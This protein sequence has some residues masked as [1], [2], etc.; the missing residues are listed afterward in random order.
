ITVT[1]KLGAWPVVYA[2]M[3]AHL[4]PLA[5]KQPLV[6]EAYYCF[7]EVF[8][9]LDHAQGTM[10]TPIVWDRGMTAT[11]SPVKTMVN[12]PDHVTTSNP[13]LPPITKIYGN[14]GTGSHAS[15]CA[16]NIA[17][18]HTTHKGAAY[19]IPRLYSADGTGDS[20]APASWNAAIS[21]GISFGNCSWWNG[22]KGSIVYLD[23]FFDYT[24]RNYSMMMFKSTGNQGNTSTPYTTSPG[25]GY[26]S[27]NSGSY[28]DKNNTVWAGDSMASYS[29]YW[30]PS[31]GHEK[32]ELANAGDDVDTTGTSGWY[33][34]F[35][36]TSSASPLTCGVATLMATRDNALMTKP[37][38]V[39]AVL[40]ASAW[41]NIE[42]DDVLS[43]KDGAGGVHALAAD[44]CLERGNYRAVT[45]T[46]SDFNNPTNSYD[47]TIPAAAG[48]DVRVCGLWFS[49]ANSAYSTD[50]LEMDLDLTI[51]SPNGTVV[52]SSA[53][54]KNAFEIL[55]FSAPVSGKYTARFVSAH[56]R[57]TT[58]PFCVAWSDRYDTGEARIEL[59]GTPT[60][61]G[62]FSVVCHAPFS[63][64]QTL[65]INFSGGGLPGT[66][67][68]G[69]GHVLAL[70]PDAIY[71]W[72]ATQSNFTN[73][74]SS[75]GS[76]SFLASVP[77]NPVYAGRRI[78]VA[79]HVRPNASSS[80]ITTVSRTESFVIQP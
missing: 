76:V 10:R 18:N 69:S 28:S 56:F 23:R 49:K 29:S 47:V 43:E 12:H 20:G 14:G 74:L 60:V 52:A 33:T 37:E 42:G 27:T 79:A 35:G 67:N 7:P 31:Q 73:T 11:G 22:S 46:S 51:L 32:P 34:G 71:N 6:D 55:K 26:N 65:Q 30:D 24:I 63:P 16:G 15:A 53:N 3:P 2:T 44:S 5:A 21:N 61:G 72:S 64:N 38:A 1:D 25:N 36:G 58:E 9:E 50:V 75:A 17:M 8:S 48:Q 40:M 77:N 68:L 78:W 59:L 45:L 70:R 62:S 41:H 66:V 54:T 80:D 13:Y 19:G 39:K 4:V 57:G